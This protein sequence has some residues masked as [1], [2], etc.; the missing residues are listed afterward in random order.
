ATVGI[1]TGVFAKE[2]M[3]GTLNSIYSQLAGEDNPNQGVAAEKFDFWGQ[4]KAAIATI[5]ANL[6][7]LPNQLLDP[8]GLNIGDL[9]DQKTAAEEQEVD[10]GIFGAMAK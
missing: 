3:V 2:A 8:L 1:F 9:Q 4:I 7:Q 10:L 6:A 5:P